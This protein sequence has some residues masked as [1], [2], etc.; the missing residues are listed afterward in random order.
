MNRKSDAGPEGRPLNFS[1]A[2]E[3]WETDRQDCGALEARHYRHSGCRASGARTMLR[4]RSQ[5]F[6]AGLKFGYRPYGPR[7]DSRF[8]AGYHTPLCTARLKPCPSFD[9]LCQRFLF[10]FRGF[11][12]CLFPLSN[13]VPGFFR[14]LAR[15]LD[16]L[17][18]RR[19]RL[20]SRFW[21][22][23]C[24]LGW[25]RR[26][27]DRQK[28]WQLHPPQ[29]LLMQLF[30]EVPLSTSLVHLEQPAGIVIIPNPTGKACKHIVY[31]CL[32]R[33][34]RRQ[35]HPQESQADARRGTPAVLSDLLAE[36][37]G[38]SQ[39]LAQTELLEERQRRGGRVLTSYAARHTFQNAEG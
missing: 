1:P 15:L 33:F 13:A 4:N 10:S 24:A 14:L 39:R 23:L 37:E 11:G 5:P 25:R 19:D 21:G 8:I 2:R 26:R 7:S 16:R 27:L 32:Y 20:H 6:R 9:S 31:R 38:P 35:D 18:D 12:S 22:R 17:F 34:G 3:G 36:R 28:I 30:V 29:H